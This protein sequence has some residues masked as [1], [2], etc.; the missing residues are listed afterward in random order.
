MSSGTY[1]HPPVKAVGI[2]K[3]IGG[4]RILGIPTVADRI[5]QMIVK[6]K[7]ECKLEKILK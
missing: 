3:K 4:I 7:F 1:F 6:L 5:A 2:P